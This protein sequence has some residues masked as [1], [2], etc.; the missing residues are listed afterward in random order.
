MRN[1]T[2]ESIDKLFSAKWNLPQA[3]DNCDLSYD[4]M[5]VMFN[6]YCKS[7]P[8]LYNEDGTLNDDSN[9]REN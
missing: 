9:R 6:H 1:E 5:R 2:Q 4:E 7:H 3:A 8:P